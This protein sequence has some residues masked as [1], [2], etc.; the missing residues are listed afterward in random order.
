M[1]KNK[2]GRGFN[3]LRILLVVA[4]LFCGWRM[5]KRIMLYQDLK[6]DAVLCQQQ[7]DSVQAEYDEKLATIELLSDDAYIERL[8]R[9]NLGMVVSGETPVYTVKVPAPA[10]DNPPIEGDV[11]SDDGAAADGADNN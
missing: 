2:R 10:A 6:A 7:L 4:I 9:E 3:W 5:G 8:A 11:P 1:M